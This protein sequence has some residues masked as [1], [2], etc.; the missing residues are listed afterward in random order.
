[1]Y[2]IALCAAIMAVSSV[3]TAAIRSITGASPLK[4]AL[5][6]GLLF[7]ISV[8]GDGGVSNFGDADPLITF[9]NTV[10]TDQV[11]QVQGNSDNPGTAYG[12]GKSP[13]PPFTVPA[14]QTVNFHPGVGFVGA[15]SA[16]SG[17]GT[18][19]EVNFRGT[20]TWYNADMEYGMSNST[21]GTTDG[22]LRIDGGDSLAGEQDCLAKANSGW[23]NVD[24]TQQTAL[25]ATGFLSG[26]NGKLTSVSM[27]ATA[28]DSV[29]KFF[30]MT[31][32]FNAYVDAGSVT[33]ET[34]DEMAKVADQFSYSV[35]TNKLTIT[36]YD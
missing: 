23:T 27:G 10:S 13:L 9:V 11:Y 33:G 22:S 14:G 2:L 29:V 5:F 21:L 8:A 35:S 17:Q 25:L 18:R 4:L 24:P 26:T 7:A 28:P 15:F 12:A 1:M 32:E 19:H 30:Q 36:A 20:P 31:A 16:K 3:R 6:F 34:Q